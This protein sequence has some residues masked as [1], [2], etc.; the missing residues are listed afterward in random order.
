MDEL[1][2]QLILFIILD[3][4]YFM[5]LVS[6]LQLKVIIEIGLVIIASLT[7]INLIHQFIISL[8]R[9]LEQQEELKLQVS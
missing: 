9:L 7:F 6:I 5:S 1:F 2:I 8:L 3:Y 4:Y